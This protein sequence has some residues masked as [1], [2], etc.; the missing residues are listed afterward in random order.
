MIFENI[1]FFIL[2]IVVIVGAGRG[3]AQCR[4]EEILSMCW[5]FWSHI[6]VRV[7]SFVRLFPRGWL[8]YRMLPGVG[9]LR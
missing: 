1:D 6:P 9:S 8:E 3:I 5:L 7:S 4:Y 2:G